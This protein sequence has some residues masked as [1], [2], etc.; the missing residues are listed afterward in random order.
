MGNDHEQRISH[1]QTKSRREFLI[2]SFAV[3][4][5]TILGAL[6]DALTNIAVVTKSLPALARVHWM[7]WVCSVPF[8]FAVACYVNDRRPEAKRLLKSIFRVPTWTQLQA[9]GD[10][11]VSRISYWALA[12]IPIIAYFVS[13]NPFK[14]NALDNFVFPLSFKLAFF[15]SWFFSV[16]LV[17]FTVGCPK[18]FRL[19]NPLEDAK[20]INLVLNEVNQPR[21]V[22]EQPHPVDDPIL[23][24]SALELRAVSFLFYVLGLA[25]FIVILLRSAWLVVNA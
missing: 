11:R 3:A 10:Q 20:T 6:V 13:T 8:L 5:A 17:L 4:L 1:P 9:F 19:T 15:V 2:S 21:I 12:L 14:L 24:N 22:I 23:D 16:A 7:I 18:E 25:V